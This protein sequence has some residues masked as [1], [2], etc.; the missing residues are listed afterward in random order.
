MTDGLISPSMPSPSRRDGPTRNNLAMLWLKMADLVGAYQVT[1]EIDR[2]P[3][4][5]DTPHSN[6][7]A[8]SAHVQNVP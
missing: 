5:T 8:S 3:H 1:S 7:V 2:S 6:T 4:Q